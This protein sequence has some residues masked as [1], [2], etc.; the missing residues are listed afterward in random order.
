MRFGVSTF[1]L[2]HC[3]TLEIFLPLIIADH[4]NFDLHRPDDYKA[5]SQMAP[6]Y[7]ELYGLSNLT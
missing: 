3:K 1:F 5:Q 6:K 7:S 4:S 2:S